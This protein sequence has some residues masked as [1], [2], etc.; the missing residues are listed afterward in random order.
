MDWQSDARSIIRK[1][2]SAQWHALDGEPWR[3]DYFQQWLDWIHRQHVDQYRT[4]WRDVHQRGTPLI[5]A[6]RL[7]LPSGRVVQCR[8]QAVPR[9]VNRELTGFSGECLMTP[10]DV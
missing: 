8:T 4:A 7:T 3:Q 2:D 5:A 1:V 6:C 10:L 9:I